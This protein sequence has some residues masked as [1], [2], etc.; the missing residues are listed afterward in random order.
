MSDRLRAAQ[1]ELAAMRA[2]RATETPNL[3]EPETWTAPQ[4]VTPEWKRVALEAVTELARTRPT[5][6]V[7]DLLPLLPP[8]PDRRAAG[9]VLV[10]AKKRRI[11]RAGE[12]V[13]GG[14]TRH[15][16]PVREWVSRIF[17]SEAA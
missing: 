9:A 14:A 1:A 3:L 12:W 7:A 11:I 13:N 2:Q 6:T 17:E 4:S 16:R 5:F 8:C 15:G 10:A